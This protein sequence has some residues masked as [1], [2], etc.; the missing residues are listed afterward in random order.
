MAESICLTFVSKCCQRTYDSV[1]YEPL[2]AVVLSE[3]LK[4]LISLAVAAHGFFSNTEDS[5]AH[6]PDFLSHV[7]AG[8]DSSAVPAFLYT[9]S[10][11]SQ[12]LGAYHLDI[13]P[14]LMLSQV[15]LILTPVF[16]RAFLKQT[17]QPH[18]WLCLVVM[19]TGM[20]LVQVGCAARSFGAPRAD[21]AGKDMIFGIVAML[22]AGFCSAFAGVYMEAVLKTSENSFMVRN[23]QL[24]G[25]TCLCALGGLMWQSD[26][27][28][29][30]SFR[31]YTVL[32]WALVLLQAVGGFLVSWAVRIA[33]TIAKN[34]AQ[35]LG[36]L[37]AL[38]IP[39]VLS[40]H[41]LSTELYC[42][43]ALVLGGVFGSLWKKE[44][45]INPAERLEKDE[46]P[47]DASMV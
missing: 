32:V 28:M 13:L 15:K 38:T 6:S 42:G 12:S 30:G 11:T 1:R 27:G 40:P 47:K 45:P 22:V 10:A 18:Q 25:Y 24:A 26:L 2:S 44:A 23:A 14:Y 8:H 31:G 7:L 29:E 33:S 16:S 41:A 4:M 37:A 5:A 36:F 19:T 20:V 46:K 9:L 43:I 3:G 34:Y 35:S 39:L 21:D 17:L